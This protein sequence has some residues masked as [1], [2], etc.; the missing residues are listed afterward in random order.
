MDGQ[1][2]DHAPAPVAE[3]PHGEVA[4]AVWGAFHRIDTI[5]GPLF[6]LRLSCGSAEGR[7]LVHAAGWSGLPQR[8]ILIR[9]RHD[10]GRELVEIAR[11]QRALLDL[12]L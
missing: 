9:A 8:L 11:G 4:L 3:A 5:H 7:A 6:R 1:F 12:T 10:V 2:K